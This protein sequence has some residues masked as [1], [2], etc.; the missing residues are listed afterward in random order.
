MKTFFAKQSDVVK[1][2]VVI[3][4]TDAP[5]GRVASKAASIIRGKTK[6]IYTPHVDTGDNV[7]IINAA[8]VKLTGQKW[9]DKIYYHHTGWPGGIKSVT[10]KEVLEKRPS[11]LLKKAIYG[12]LPKNRLGKT[13]NN[14]YRIYDNDQHPHTGQNPE[15]IAL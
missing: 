2:W 1:K 8:K 11:D 13:L 12:M 4:A 15:V 14:N 6:P 3:D 7:I 5:L 9:D 10:A